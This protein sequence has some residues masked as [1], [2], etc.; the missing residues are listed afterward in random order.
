MNNIFKK[1]FGIINN[2]IVKN[3]GWLIGGKIAQMI[4]NL[5]VGLMTARYLGPS[6]YGLINYGGA[7]IAFFLSLCTLGV[8]SV[9]VKEFIDHPKQEG[10]VLGTSIGLKGISSI[11]SATMIVIIVSV[12]DS[13]EPTTILVVALCSIGLIFSIFDTFNYWFQANLMSKVTAVSSLLAF[14]ITAVYRIFLLISG[15]SIEFFAFATSVDYISLSIF[16]YIAYKKYEG[17]KL[18]FSWNYAKQLLKASTPF[19]IPSLMVA[20]YGQTDK[21]MLKQMLGKAEVGY[22]STAVSICTM[23]CFVISA[24]IDS[25]YPIIM[26][27][28]NRSEREF[29][30]KNKILYAIVFYICIFVSMVITLLADNIVIILYGNQ[31]LPTVEPLRIIT[32]Y[33]A[34]SYLGVARNAWIVCKNKQK[35]LKYVYLMAALANIILNL[36]FIPKWGAS[37]AALASLAAQ[38]ITTIVVPFFMPSLC[39]N[40]IMMVQAICLQFKEK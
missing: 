8:N 34:F 19:I 1:L 10:T 4:I 26:K 6:N 39:E 16:L 12:V 24:I 25:M 3:A 14:L 20:V 15:K 5:F 37:G 29:I 31:Y 21:L 30:Y 36:W 9:I 11:L 33:T 13:G 38:V 7:Y 22:Y 27:A 35:K 32:W 23:W 28:N 18:R 40:S 17:R 2:K